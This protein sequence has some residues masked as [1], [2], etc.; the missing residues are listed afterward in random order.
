[1]TKEQYCEFGVPYDLRVLE[2][3]KA[4]WMNTLHAH[5]VN[6]MFELLKD[7]P[8]DVFNW[9]A[10]ETLPAV[11]EAA[12]LTGKCLMGGLKRSDITNK[13]RNEILHQTFQCYR[14]TGGIK[15]ILTPGCVVRYPLDR[16]TLHFVKEARDLV[17]AA[18]K[19]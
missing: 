9:H 8:I 18:M 13:N 14:L 3:A 5:G 19:R 17:E 11:D 10:W 2:A 6:I 4:G 7:Y 16:D 15:H 12:V 1:M